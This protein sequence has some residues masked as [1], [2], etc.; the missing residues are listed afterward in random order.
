MITERPHEH[1]P[2][3]ILAV[4][5]KGRPT[6]YLSFMILKLMFSDPNRWFTPREIA[7]LL[8]AKCSDTD[9]ICRQLELVDLLT[10]NPSQPGQYQYN[11]SSTN[12]DLQVGF[13]TFLVD[14]ELESLPVH[15]ML[16]YS[17]SFR[18]PG[19][20]PAACPE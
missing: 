13:E 5:A 20:M 7:K 10:E 15:L 12:V 2:W 4:D 14:V 16:A 8:A 9:M 6:T 11:W 19:H 3:D 1:E 18:S 17:P